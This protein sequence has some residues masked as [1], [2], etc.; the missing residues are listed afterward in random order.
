MGAL[1]QLFNTN[2][3]VAPTPQ[4]RYAAALRYH[5]EHIAP[6]ERAAYKKRENIDDALMTWSSDSKRL[7][8]GGLGLNWDIHRFKRESHTDWENRTQKLAENLQEAVGDTATV[9]SSKGR[10][11]LETER[12]TAA[13]RAIH[14]M[15]EH[16]PH[17][18]APKPEDYGI[19]LPAPRFDYRASIEL[20]TPEF[21]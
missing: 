7:K 16:H 15:V 10:I 11:I 5:R 1:T 20:V 18:P 6:V 4:E 13:Y 14:R 2:I 12:G 17:T 3:K 21:S 8:V 9:Q 19:R